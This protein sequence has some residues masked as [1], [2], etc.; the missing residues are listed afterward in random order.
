MLRTETIER[1]TVELLMALMQDEKLK[2]FNLVGGTALTLYNGHRKSID[3]DLFSQP[4]FDVNELGKYLKDT[5]NFLSQNPTI[6]PGDTLIGVI[7]NIKVDCIRYDYPFVKPVFIEDGIRLLSEYDIAA[8]K[9][10]A[11][12]QSGTRLKDFV[13]VA[14]LSIKMSLNDMLNAFEVK[15]P[16]TNKI[17]AVKGLTYF[18]D[19]DFSSKIELTTGVFKWESIMKRLLEMIKYPQKVFLHPPI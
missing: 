10:T 9:L 2:N 13:D 5:Y 15:Y 12:S 19:I 6:K 16:R 18:D 17:S 7:K 4:T 8:M 14:F 3:L 1:D 11:I